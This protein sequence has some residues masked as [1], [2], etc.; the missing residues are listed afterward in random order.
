M[1][2]KSFSRTFFWTLIAVLLVA[3]VVGGWYYSSEL[4]EDGFTPSGNPIIPPGSDL[5]VEEASYPGP[6]G[7]MD[8]YFLPAEGTDTWVIHVHGKDAGPEEAAFLFE[9]IQAAGYPQ[10]WIAYR[11]DSGQASDPTGFYQY[12][13]TEWEDVDA[14]LE[15]AV[16]QGADKVV[17]SGLATGSSHVLSFLYRNRLDIVSGVI[18]DSPDIDFG[19]TVDFN[20][21]QR[22]LPVLPFNVPPTITWVAKFV[23]SLR[24]GVNWKSIDYVADAGTN[25][26]T[27]VLIH[28]G[29]EDESV[30]VSQSLAFVEE[31]RDQVRLIQVSGAGHLGSYD[32]DPNRYVEEVLVFLAEVG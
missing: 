32:A 17:F 26:R 10:L 7:E 15:F 14:A 2:S 6:L 4:I 29:T 21:S 9:P 1:T 8:A 16:D 31:A 24:I 19:D 27:P 20:S 13:A 3:H 18:M 30:P 25:L 22:E 12:G 23:T 5:V 11:N 28:H